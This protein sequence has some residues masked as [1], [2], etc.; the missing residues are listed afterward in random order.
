MSTAIHI[1][2]SPKPKIIIKTAP[3]NK[4]NPAVENKPVPD[5]SATCLR[6]RLR[7]KVAIIANTQR[8]TKII[9][10]AEMKGI[11]SVNEMFAVFGV[12]PESDEMVDQSPFQLG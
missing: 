2:I 3:I 4:S 7:R 1:R 10:A 9:I 12:V 11:K 5:F 6:E 8:M